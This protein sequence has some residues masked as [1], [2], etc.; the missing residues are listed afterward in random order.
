MQKGIL[1]RASHSSLG[2]KLKAFFLPYL[3][4]EMHCVASRYQKGNRAVRTCLQ[5]PAAREAL[6]RQTC[7]H[8]R[9]VVP[10]KKI[11]K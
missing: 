11:M 3:T 6:Q 2:L 1:Q 4:K 9:G 10:G 5:I 8:A 7:T